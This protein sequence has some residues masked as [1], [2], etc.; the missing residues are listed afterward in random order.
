MKLLGE[1]QVIV[2]CD[3]IQADGGTRTASITGGFV[4]LASAF[5]VLKD[6]QMILNYPITDYVAAVSCGI[7]NGEPRL[8]LN[9]EED[10]SAEVDMNFV[11]TGSGKFVE[12]QG[13]AE[14]KPFDDNQMQQMIQLARKGHEELFKVQESILGS[15]FKRPRVQS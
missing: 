14:S 1:R 4:A 10:S 8:D 9:Y 15:F 7:I 12:V 3:V 5:H 13:T 6:Q 2:D 11:M